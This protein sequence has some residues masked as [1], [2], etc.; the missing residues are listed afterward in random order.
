[1]R[2][3]VLYVKPQSEKRVADTLKKMNVEFFCPT[4]KET[5]Q[6]SDRKKEIEV[7]LFKSYVFVK[8]REKERYLVFD[9]PGVVRYL[10]WLGKPAIVLQEEIDVIKDWL[11]DD[12]VDQIALSQYNPG[13]SIKIKSGLL[14]D[15]EAIIKHVG[16][17]KM[18]LVLKNVGVIIHA[19]I[20]EVR[21]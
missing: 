11:N 21:G 1:M 18:S 15:Q 14:K 20:K 12:L 3:F 9:V 6:W 2:W 5:R 8:L 16:N 4:V 10:F 17:T 7:P 13:D 19:R